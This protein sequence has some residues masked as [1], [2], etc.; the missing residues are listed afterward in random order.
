MIKVTVCSEIMRQK[1]DMWTWYENYKGFQ[2]P[3]QWLKDYFETPTNSETQ[4]EYLLHPGVWT[5]S[6]TDQVWATVGG[7]DFC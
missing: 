6:G 2:A 7:H 4:P 5:S 3:G 1:H